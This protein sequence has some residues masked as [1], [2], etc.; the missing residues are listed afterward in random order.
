MDGFSLD[1][2]KAAMSALKEALAMNE[3]TAFFEDAGTLAAGAQLSA[4][5]LTTYCTKNNTSLA[6]MVAAAVER[7]QD[8]PASEPAVSEVVEGTF[9]DDVDDVPFE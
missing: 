8:T 5:A 7:F 2:V 1:E 9:V 6:N 3:I 4:K